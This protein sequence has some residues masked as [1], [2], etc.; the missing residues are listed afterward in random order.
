MSERNLVIAIYSFGG[1]EG[2]RHEMLNLGEELLN[3]L[4][5]YGITVAYEPLLGYVDEKE[6]YDVVFIEGAVTSTKEVK[7]LME[8]RSKAKILVALG[9][10][11]YLGGI[12]ALMKDVK[13]ELTKKFTKSPA[14][15]PVT[16]SPIGKYVKIDYWLRGCP[17]NKFELTALLKTIAEGRYF[18]QGIKRF[19]FCRDSVVDIRGKLIGL[20]GEKCLI[21]GRCVGICSNIGVNA[22]GH[23][24]RGIN[25]AVAT[26]FQEPL[27][28]TTCI[29]CGLC[30]A[31]CPV[32]AINYTNNIQLVQDMFKN[33]EKLVAYVEYEALAALAEA[34][35]THPN[36]LVTAIKKLGFDKVVLWTPLA[37]VRPSADLSILPMSHAEHKYISQFYPDLKKYLTQPPSMRIPYRGVLITQCVARKVYSDYVLTAR[38]LQ[39]MIKKLNISDLESSEPDHVFK[40]AI[41]GYL[42]AVGP[43]ELK[44]V[45]ETV[46]RGVIKSGVIVTYIC[47][48]GCLMGGGQPHSKLPF[49]VCVEC[50]ESYFDKFMKAYIL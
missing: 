20:D 48:N 29:T 36:K 11:S 10:C 9:S 1:C 37:N 8:L 26:P 32:G 49:E 7:K 14:I 2:C 16:A 28:N 12:P 46:R 5:K 27:D 6:E 33:G 38:E 21:C 39:M 15:I 41:Y 45:L 30:T 13:D 24:N 25:I 4:A 17:I 42:K 3:L 43:Y 31:Y 22:L 18:R 44:G 23:V 50:R 35:E 40:P 19:N 47:P 34:E